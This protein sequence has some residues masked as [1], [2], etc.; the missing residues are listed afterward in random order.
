MMITGVDGSWIFMRVRASIP[1]IPGIRTSMTTKSGLSA[2]K[3]SKPSSPEA[4]PAAKADKIR[5]LGISGTIRVPGN[6]E[7]RTL[8]EQ[9]YGLDLNGWL[10]LFARAGTPDPIVTAINNE[11]LRIM[12]SEEAQSRL[13]AMNIGVFPPNTPEQYAQTVQRDLQ[14]WK[15]IITDNNIKSD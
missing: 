4:A 12:T 13:T 7:I 3:R 8:Q 6:P 5:L 9:G 11:V 1:V 2:F 15:K 10:G 14:A